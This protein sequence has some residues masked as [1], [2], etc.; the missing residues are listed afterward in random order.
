MPAEVQS[1][2]TRA[3]PERARELRAGWAKVGVERL[4][5]GAPGLLSYNLGMVSRADLKRL[6]QLQRA[7]Y[8]KLVNIIAES[9]PAEC[10]VCMPPS[11][12]N[13]EAGLRAAVIRAARSSNSLEGGRLGGTG[14]A[15]R[16]FT[17]KL[18]ES[19]GR[20]GRLGRLRAETA[21]AAWIPWP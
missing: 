21:G 6:E 11:C 10:V 15:K 5:A 3:D 12:S 16:R 9:S 13:C 20:F 17:P 19:R 1:V 14:Y 7:H 8:R 2:D 4:R 18:S